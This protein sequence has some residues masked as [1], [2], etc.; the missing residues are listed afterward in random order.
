M[1]SDSNG[2]AADV[3][4]T[5]GSERSGSPAGP[6]AETSATA[7]PE[8]TGFIGRHRRAAIT[9]LVGAVAFGFVYFI[10]PQIADL[11]P[12][13]RRLR[14]GNPWWL[15]LG[16]PLE[17][18]SIVAYAVLFRGVFAR[19]DAR[20]GWRASFQITLAGGG[21]TKLLAAAGSG[22]VAV[23]VWALRA[24]GLA[25]EEVAPGVV[26]FEILTHAVYM[27]ALAVAGFGLWVA[28]F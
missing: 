21:A 4:P 13:L 18:L 15:G 19:S 8:H 23:T 20:I 5:A 12:T 11:G 25:V 10:V 24:S 22:G 26:S 6:G 3:G 17:A 28:L 14:S 9:V 27:A 2:K 7:E 16:V 1:R